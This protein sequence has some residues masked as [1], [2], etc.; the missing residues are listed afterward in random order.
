MEDYEKE[1]KEHRVRR[2]WTRAEAKKRG[3]ATFYVEHQL[4]RECHLCMH[5]HTTGAISDGK[6][7]SLG[8]QG[9]RRRGLCTHTP[10]TTPSHIIISIHSHIWISPH[11]SCSI[12]VE[13]ENASTM[14]MEMWMALVKEEG[15]GAKE[16][17]RGCVCGGGGGGDRGGASDDAWCDDI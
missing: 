7:V 11:P 16:D 8:R 2:G 9:E 15:E 3:R 12:G 13:G 14:E 1:E 10:T 5:L 17:E 6:G 4:W